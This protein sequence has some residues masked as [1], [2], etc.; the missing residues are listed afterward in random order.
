MA[1]PAKFDPMTSS[2]D[3][4]AAAIR[5]LERE[6][7]Q[8]ECSAAMKVHVILFV[9]HSVPVFLLHGCLHIYIYIS[10]NVRLTEDSGT[11]IRF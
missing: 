9:L 1:D 4:V 8:S 11:V 2:R 6:L 3:D 7:K 5:R 10:N